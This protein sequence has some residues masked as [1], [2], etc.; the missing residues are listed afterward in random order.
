LTRWLRVAALLVAVP[1]AA[2]KPEPSL[3]EVTLSPMIEG[4]DALKASNYPKARTDF[5]AAQALI[6]G[7]PLQA[8]T[9]EDRAVRA[10]IAYLTAKA[11]GEGKLGDACPILKRAQSLVDGAA[12]IAAKQPGIDQPREIG[13]EANADLTAANVKFGCTKALPAPKGTIPG[14][15]A[16]HYYLSGVR[17]TGS[18]LMLRPDGSYDYYISYGA[19]DQ[20]SKGTWQKVGD[21]VI[22]THTKTPSGGAL[23]K[24]DSLEPWDVDAEAF[25]QT[26]RHEARV[27]VVEATCPFLAELDMSNVNFPP[28]VVAMTSSPF[29]NSEAPKVDYARV[30]AQAKVTEERSRRAYE[31]AAQ[32]AM[33]PGKTDTT[34]HDTA[35]G[36]RYE[37]QSAN[38]ELQSARHRVESRDALPK[39]PVLPPKCQLPEAVEASDIPEKDWVRGFGVIVGDPV[40]GAKFSNVRVR[41]H[42]ADGQT[43]DLKTQRRGFA[44]VE[45]RPGITVTAMSLSY[46]RAMRPDAPFERFAIANGAEGVQRVIIDSRQLVDPPFD[47]MRL[48]IEDGGLSG[49]RDRGRYT[50]RD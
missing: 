27:K 9:Y 8:D 33:V 42:F 47:E 15:L 19:V 24:L 45:K 21:A 25:V 17:E 34:R 40:A 48:R 38:D 35:R 2:Q 36:M 5:L 50:K 39:P 41:F 23:F 16:G 29:L 4:L 18:E 3:R 10:A 7:R 46:E 32:A 1:S 6:D 11:T 37:W 26:A 30:Y 20:F 13:T 31:R 43:M 44:W 14:E 49:P 12:E 28:P 22:L